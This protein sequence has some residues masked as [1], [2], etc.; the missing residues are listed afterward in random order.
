MA[1]LRNILVLEDGEFNAFLIKQYFEE[2]KYSYTLVTN[3]EEACREADK[4]IYDAA[5]IDCRVYPHT[6]SGSAEEKASVSFLSHLALVGSTL[7]VVV[8]SD[9]DNNE[10]DVANKAGLPFL[11]KNDWDKSLISLL[12][13]TIAKGIHVNKAVF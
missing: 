4:G 3:C 11:L 7:P 9:E 8:T 12:E 6:A 1:N 2:A 13:D 5:L 10:H